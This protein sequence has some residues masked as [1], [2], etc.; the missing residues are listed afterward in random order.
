M[1]INQPDLAGAR[2]LLAEDEA[3]I[4][5]DLSAGVEDA[6]GVALG[7]FAT[8]REALAA[9]ETNSVEGAILDVDLADGMVAPVM[10]KLTE[11]GVPF[12]IHTGVGLPAEVRAEFPLARVFMKPTLPE[13][14]VNA[15]ARELNKRSSSNR[16]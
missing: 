12:V 11:D 3:L 14:L 6:G 2:I 8:V 7:P 13:S 15:L 5:F 9:M 1:R 16:G 10:R 4:G